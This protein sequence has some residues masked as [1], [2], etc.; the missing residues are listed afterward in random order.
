MGGRMRV[1]WRGM[2]RLALAVAVLMLAAV[3]S[4]VGGCGSGNSGSPEAQ[5]TLSPG[6][7]QSTVLYPV[8][9][10][11]SASGY[12]DKTGKM[13]I[14]AQFAE[15]GPFSGGL[16]AVRLKA[17]GPWGYID[18][19]GQ[20]VI[21]PQFAA[22]TPF[23]EGLAAVAIEDGGDWGF[24]DAS[25][26]VV[27]APQFASAHGFSEG[28]ACV[29]TETDSGY[30]D[31]TGRWTITMNANKATSDYDAVGEFS[32]GLALV[33]DRATS[34][35]GYVDK[36]GGIAI[37]PAY[38]DAWGFSEDLAAVRLPTG[39][40][41]YGYIDRH[42]EW[43]IQPQFADARPFSEGLAAAQSASTGTWGYVDATGTA[44]VEWRWDLAEP[45]DQSIA[46]VAR[47][48]GDTEAGYLLY[49]YAYID[50]GGKVIWRDEALIAFES[51]VT[52]TTTPDP[53]R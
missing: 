37:Q 51:G 47:R 46:R 34:L 33:Y 10:A 8:T 9:T 2:A 39:P 32:T 28:L 7:A 31:P 4:F 45:F 52:T 44:V 40:R 19:T 30:I 16:A 15:A 14:A 48:V 6:S 53:A 18:A 50:I 3:P 5:T 49:G 36:D 23:S 22:A 41:L 25:G 1:T 11:G 27:I 29:H 43:V 20:V 26:A 12:I 17:Y 42:G 21:Q 13:I 38:T 24:I 35:Y